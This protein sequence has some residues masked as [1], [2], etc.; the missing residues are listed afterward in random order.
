M[1]NYN[2][3]SLVD[4][5]TRKTLLTTSSARKC[6]KAFIKGYRIDVWNENILVDIIYNKNINDINK[7]VRREK[8]YIAKKQEAATLRNKIRKEKRKQKLAKGGL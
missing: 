6:K 8:E 1:A 3:F 5:K 4:T 2:T 7:Y